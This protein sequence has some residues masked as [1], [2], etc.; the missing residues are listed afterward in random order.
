MVPTPPQIARQRP[1]PLLRRSDE[2]IQ[3][4]RLAHHRRH[5]GRGLRQHLNLIF[6]ESSGLDGLHHQ[7]ALQNAPVDQ[8]NA[9]ER[10]V[11]VFAGFAKY[12]KRG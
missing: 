4:A 1:K 9:R 5:L 8:R 3:R 2:A 7:H 6:A 10:L 11:S 12:L